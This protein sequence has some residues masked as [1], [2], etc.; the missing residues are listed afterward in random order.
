MRCSILVGDFVPTIS[1]NGEDNMSSVRLFVCQYACLY[2]VTFLDYSCSPSRDPLRD[3]WEATLAL[4]YGLDHCDS[5]YARRTIFPHSFAISAVPATACAAGTLN[6][7]LSIGQDTAVNSN[8]CGRISA[9]FSWPMAYGTGTTR[10]NS[11]HPCPRELFSYDT[12]TV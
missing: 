11:E 10:L 3:Y 7:P 1:Y 4:T 5:G 8:D 6:T 9:K 12:P 2:A